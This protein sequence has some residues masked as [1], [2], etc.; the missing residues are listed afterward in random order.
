MVDLITLGLS[1]L[2]VHVVAITLVD[3]VLASDHP[4]HLQVS[5]FF[6]VRRL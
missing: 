3:R 1:A 2:E 4:V 6:G 5:V